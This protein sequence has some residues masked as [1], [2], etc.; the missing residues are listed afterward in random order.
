M[1][2]PLSREPGGPAGAG[3][4]LPS[5]VHLASERR[6]DPAAADRWFHLSDAATDPTTI[7]DDGI[8]SPAIAQVV[9]FLLAVV[10]TIYFGARAFDASPTSCTTITTMTATTSGGSTQTVSSAEC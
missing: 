8:R 2:L 6:L 4:R 3:V 1:P 5:V 7:D 10:A 9:C